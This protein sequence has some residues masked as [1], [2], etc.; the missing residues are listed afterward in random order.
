[1][2]AGIVLGM[3]VTLLLAIILGFFLSPD[4]AWR[5]RLGTTVLSCLVATPAACALG[6]AVGLSGRLRR[7]GFGI[8]I[9][10]IL[11]TA[12]LSGLFLLASQ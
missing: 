10:S 5:V 2:G 12:V 1:M 9:G 4:F 11:I 7:L 6:F 3:V 8:A